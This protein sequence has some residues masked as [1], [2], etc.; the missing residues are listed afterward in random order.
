MDELAERLEAASLALGRRISHACDAGGTSLTA[1]Q[2][3][4][5]RLLDV[6]EGRRSSD[7]ADILGV[8][9]SAVT[10]IVD[11][12]EERGLVERERD[13]EDRRVV[14]VRMTGTGRGEYDRAH[15]SVRVYMR[16]L[17]DRLDPEETTAF[18][19]IL[20]K[21]AATAEERPPD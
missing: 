17:L 14:R 18:V 12:L 9:P 13:A 1:S 3:H 15:E 19:Q 20:E 11:R 4:L 5:L 6:P 2:H 21:L 10:A 8:Q 16:A 7:I